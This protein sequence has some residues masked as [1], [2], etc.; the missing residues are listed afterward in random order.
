M[1]PRN[2]GQLLHRPRPRRCRAEPGQV[3]PLRDIGGVRSPTAW[4][5]PAILAQSR[6][7][8]RRRVRNDRPNRAPAR[9]ERRL[10]RCSL[11]FGLRGGVPGA[12]EPRQGS[13]AS[14]R[15]AC[16]SRSSKHRSAP[17]RAGSIREDVLC[18]RL[19][20]RRLLVP[21][22]GHIAE[23]QFQPSWTIVRS[24]KLPRSTL[25]RWYRKVPRAD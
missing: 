21:R 8:L 20:V 14:S 19:H 16:S 25:L 9:G 4:H 23:A 17:T 22:G 5:R 1:A 12:A 6:W 11:R 3:D 15:W 10:V 7:T 2:R 24:V 18:S 13:S